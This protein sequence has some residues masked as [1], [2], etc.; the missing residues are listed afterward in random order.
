MDGMR[1]AVLGEA[2]IDL[3]PGPA[4]DLV[5]RPGGSP[6]NVAVGLAR[7]DVPTAFLGR[8]STDRWGNMIRRHLLDNGVA[9]AGPSGTE[10]T[11][12]ALVDVAADGEPS[13][14]FLWEGTADR[15]LDVADLPDDLNGVAIVHVG[16]LGAVLEPGA[17]AVR[18]LVER[19][20]DDRIVTFDPNVRPELVADADAVRASL[21][22]LARSAHV[23]KASDA[24]LAWLVPGTPADDIAHDLAARDV[25]LVA[26]TAGPRPVRLVGQRAEIEIAPRGGPVVDTVGAGDA[27]MAGLI[28]GLLDAGLD[29]PQRLHTAGPDAL[30][31]AGDLAIR[32]AAVTASRAG[33]DPPTR[34]ELAQA[35]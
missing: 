23:V 7:L 21:L 32:A 4:A 35:P 10:P 33:A 18:S 34:A 25:S 6:A 17:T 14:R 5:A 2:L 3:L 9:V 1:V 8:T 12:I 26:I 13:Y 27:F 19:E 30:R 29:T 22:D 20:R 28:A 24:D 15:L 31:A 11:A 16:S